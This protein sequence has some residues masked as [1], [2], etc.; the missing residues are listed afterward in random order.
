MTKKK[1]IA[2]VVIEAGPDYLDRLET[3]EL[4]LPEDEAQAV[5]EAIEAVQAMGYTVIP[6]D[7][8]GCNEFV[9]VS[10]GEDYIAITVY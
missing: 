4:E 9:S 5:A 2:V 10:G 3:F 7:Q 1:K 8:G 6:D